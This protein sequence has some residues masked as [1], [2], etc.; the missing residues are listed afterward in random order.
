MK[1]SI[2][3][4]RKTRRKLGTNAKDGDTTIEKGSARMWFYYIYFAMLSA[5]KV[6]RLAKKWGCG[7]SISS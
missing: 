2:F 6:N 4:P 3:G 1:E 5:P 7:H